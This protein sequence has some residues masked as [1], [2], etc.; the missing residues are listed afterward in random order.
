MGFTLSAAVIPSPSPALDGAD[1]CL[2]AGGDVHVL[3][4]NPLLRALP[5]MAVQR[6][7]QGRGCAAQFV[8]LGKA[9]VHP[10]PPPRSWAHSDHR[11]RR[12]P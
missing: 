11:S 9:L 1:D 4:D 10:R 8:R 3:D 5:A 6:F 7:H 12:A 2:S